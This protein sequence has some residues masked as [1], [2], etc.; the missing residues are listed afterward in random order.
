MKKIKI[1]I[2]ALV[3]V[4]LIGSA[5]FAVLFFAT[6]IFKSDKQL[7]CKYAEQIGF[8]EFV[9]LEGYNDYLKRTESQ[10]HSTNGA[11]NVSL[12]QEAD[13]INESIKYARIYRPSK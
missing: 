12:T 2:I 11:F 5:T 3:S 8:K 10:G 13:S 7:F 9:D 1:I 6:D 4:L